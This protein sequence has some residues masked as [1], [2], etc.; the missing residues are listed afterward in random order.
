MTTRTIHLVNLIEHERG[1][2]SKIDETLEFPTYDKA[3]EHV[4]E[5]N[6][7]NIAQ[8]V[9]D[10]YMV[11]EYAGTKEVEYTGTDLDPFEVKEI[12]TRLSFA[13]ESRIPGHPAAVIAKNYLKKHGLLHE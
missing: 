7:K 13:L 11:A 3:M 10:W 2:G 5:F 6:S 12:I 1:W 9:P 8:N 4:E